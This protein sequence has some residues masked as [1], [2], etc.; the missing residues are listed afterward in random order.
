MSEPEEKKEEQAQTSEGKEEQAPAKKSDML[1]Y[2]IFGL[3]GVVLVVVGVAVA[4][5]LLG[6]EQAQD[7]ETT[8]LA[9]T[10]E[11]KS[12]ASAEPKEESDEF[13][14]DA[15]YESLL[16]NE[17]DSAV[18][19]KINENLAALD[20]EPAESELESE[21]VETGMSVEDSIESVNWLKKEKADLAKRREE[22]DSQQNELNRLDREVSKKILRIE[23]V[24][25]GRVNSLAKLY[26]GMDSRAV[27][28]LMANL[29]DA[30][31]VSILPRM[32]TKNASAVLQLMP[33]RRAA[34]LSKQMI[35][36]AGK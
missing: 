33:P 29:D 9:V 25:S 22:L 6:G 35:T 18:I 17:E 10:T 31:V 16:V 12:T 28:K 15:M 13:K 24:K 27:A 2:I 8:E 34:S 26:D 21:E 32:K 11:E 19:K 23:Q 30:T 20:W 1:K 5:V 4:M 14:E 3:I 36:I 7:P